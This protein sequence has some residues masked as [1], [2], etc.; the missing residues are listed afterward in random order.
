VDSTNSVTQI[1]SD[2]RKRFR[3]DREF[4]VVDS[5]WEHLLEAS[6][7][8]KALVVASYFSYGDEPNTRNLNQTLISLGKKLLLPRLR[9]D[10]DLDW[11]IWSGRNEDLISKGLVHEAVGDLYVGDIDVV[12]VPALHVDRQG[13]RLG[14][15]G[16][17]Y[18]RTLARTKAWKVALVYPGELTSEEVPREVHDQR[19]DA[20]ATTEILVRFTEPN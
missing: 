2:L 7:V 19:V 12:I 10:K 15:G 20:A 8:K 4:L 3:A 16:G 5:S 9:D 13:N 18:D 14:Q 6:E 11:V 17:S 1:K